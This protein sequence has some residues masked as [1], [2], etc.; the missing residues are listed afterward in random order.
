[1]SR[2]QSCLHIYIVLFFRIGRIG[3]S[4]HD[5]A[6]FHVN[7]R[8]GS[9]RGPSNTSSWRADPK[10][11]IL[12]ISKEFFAPAKITS[13]NTQF[14]KGQESCDLRG[15]QMRNARIMTRISSDRKIGGRIFWRCTR[16]D[17]STSCC[18][19]CKN[20]GEYRKFA[21]KQ[22]LKQMRVDFR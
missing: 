15:E 11:H 13:K 14:R 17:S 4:E 5:V 8:P 18:I 20:W 9:V 6:G 19:G 1:V 3:Y 2:K 22:S 10:F 7:L 12:S 21:E 16:N